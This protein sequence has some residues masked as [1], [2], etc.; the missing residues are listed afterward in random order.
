MIRCGFPAV[1]FQAQRLQVVSAV[2]VTV[3]V[4]VIDLCCWDDLAFRLAPPA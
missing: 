1:T 2:V 4:Y 3:F